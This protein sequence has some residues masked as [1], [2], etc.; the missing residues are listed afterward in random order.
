MSRADKKKTKKTVAPKGENTLQR[1]EIAPVKTEN[2]S[3][4]HATPDHA[5]EKKVV[6]QQNEKSCG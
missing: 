6:A 1:K 5:R 4:K 3:N 2:T